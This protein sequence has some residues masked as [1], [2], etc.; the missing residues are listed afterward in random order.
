M[1]TFTI[2]GKEKRKEPGNQ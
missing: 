2:E 1:Q